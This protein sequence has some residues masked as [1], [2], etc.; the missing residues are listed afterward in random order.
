M[1]FHFKYLS[2]IFEVS[3]HP[4]TIGRGIAPGG[5]A[6]FSLLK[7]SAVAKAVHTGKPDQPKSGL[8]ALQHSLRRFGM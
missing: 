2:S 7:F 5:E 6:A 1:H 3:P 4:S 8:G